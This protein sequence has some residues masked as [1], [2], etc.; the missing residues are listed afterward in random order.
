MNSVGDADLCRNDKVPACF[1]VVISM[2]ISIYIHLTVGQS[3]A[4]RQPG[5][6]L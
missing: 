3:F 4:L 1:V 5:C 6:S 2:S